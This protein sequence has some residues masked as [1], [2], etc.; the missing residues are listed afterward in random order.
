[1]GATHLFQEGLLLPPMRVGREGKLDAFIEEIIGANVRNSDLFFG[2]MRAQLGVTLL[3]ADR[4]VEV[5]H[6]VGAGV[7]LDVYAELLDQGERLLR[8]HIAAWPDGEST[9]VGYLDSDGTPDGK[10]V[11]LAVTASGGRRGDL[12]PHGLRR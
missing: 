10:P 8:S 11:R 12:R 3:G 1:M 7:L 5:A 2:D 4:L 6:Q 9:A